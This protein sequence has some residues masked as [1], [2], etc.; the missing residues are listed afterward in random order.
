MFT[1]YEDKNLYPIID[2]STRY[3]EKP[4]AYV[5]KDDSRQPDERRKVIF[6]MNQFEEYVFET[7]KAEGFDSLYDW[8]QTWY[9]T[10]AMEIALSGHVAE[11]YPKNLLSRHQLLTYEMNHLV[12]QEKADGWAKADERLSEFDW[13]DGYVIVTHPHSLAELTDEAVQ[14]GNCVRRYESDIID[15][16]SNILFMRL[17]DKP[18]KSWLTIEVRAHYDGSRF[19]NQAYAAFNSRP[20]EDMVTALH[21]WCAY[22]GIDTC[23]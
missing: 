1:L 6:D 12:R 14:Q 3:W 11:K 4:A 22:K 17:A 13:T 2:A 18:K 20:N 7:S 5:D 16:T 15:G 10:L 19:V 23:F 9:D 21:K 8:L